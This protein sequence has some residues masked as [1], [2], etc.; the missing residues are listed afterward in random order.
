MRIDVA[1]G[2]NSPLSGGNGLG[3]NRRAHW[4]WVMVVL[5]AVLGPHLY[6]PAVL[7][8]QQPGPTRNRLQKPAAGG[9]ADGEQMVKIEFTEDVE[10]RALVDFVSSR[11]SVNI[12]YDETTLNKT[13]TIRAP[14]EI[15]L[16][17]LLGLL[18]SAVRMKGLML[19]DADTPGWRRIVAIEKLAQ[20]A[21]FGTQDQKEAGD[22]VTQVF[23]LENALPSKADASIKPFLTKPGAN[24]LALDD[25]GVL[26]VS[27]FAGNMGKIASLLQAID[28]APKQQDR[29]FIELQYTNAQELA[30][31]LQ[32]LLGKAPKSQPRS[33]DALGQQQSVV[34]DS[35]TNRL[36][37][38]G[39]A[40]Q[41]DLI[42]QLILQ[43]DV[44]VD[45][46]TR[47][48][49]LQYVSATR[50]DE[51][52]TELMKEESERNL[53]RSAI[54]EESNQLFV[55]ATPAI[56]KRLSEF[57][58]LLDV[59][60]ARPH[61]PI[62]FYKLKNVSAGDL[63]QTLRSIQENNYEPSEDEYQPVRWDGR[64]RGIEGY[65]IPGS[66]TNPPPIQ[67]GPTEFRGQD[68]VGSSQNAP[69]ASNTSATTTEQIASTLGEARITADES[70]NTLIIV[71][72]PD[73]QRNYAELIR[74]L[75]KRPAQVMIEAKLVII[76]ASDNFTLGVELSGGDQQ[77]LKRLFAFTSFGLSTVDPVTGALQII[78]GK[79][80]NGTLVDPDVADAVVRALTEHD[81][82]RV[83]SSPRL[84]V[85]DNAQG[86]LTSVQ[87]EPFTSVNVNNVASSTSFA[88]FAEAGTTITVTPR[89]ADHNYL[90]LE[91]QITLNTFTGNA[92]GPGIP[93]PRQ[94]AELKSKITIPNGHTVIV[95]GLRSSSSTL[96]VDSIPWVER[97]PL[98]RHLFSLTEKSKSRSSFFVFLRPVILEEEKFLDL[99]FLS[100]SEKSDATLPHT[101]P[102]SYALPIRSQVSGEFRYV[103]PEV[104]ESP[105]WVDDRLPGEDSPIDSDGAI[106]LIIPTR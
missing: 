28:T 49:S 27:D 66:F 55:T 30:I 99:R 73:V 4:T 40:E 85:N 16:K 13:L 50:I 79:G 102:P 67:P 6:S 87:E 105:T 76:D 71:A 2:Q 106:E 43:L 37:L 11:L 89:I 53:Y 24:S 1:A 15:P 18:Q 38:S 101:F 35:R 90:Q 54:D 100:E 77:G 9:R 12:L 75:D 83:I 56:H 62:R 20:V 98:V 3:I 7:F 95:G 44:P 31:L 51:L 91:Y 22:P 59:A 84:L 47:V 5:C 94:T 17:S 10:L 23:I 65:L 34:A 97:I 46:S 78:P 33:A 96:D 88:G 64:V 103:T 42:E 61:N 60:A 8:A 72:E 58:K 39:S 82:A 25:L 41:L 92:P 32:Q 26:I 80:G 29:R 36:I 21:P 81:R 57:M 69:A 70:S 68:S 93:P 52:A 74:Q 63:L 45:L 86:V 14:Q 104:V 19:A 48:Y